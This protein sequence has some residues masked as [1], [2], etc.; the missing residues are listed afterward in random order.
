MKAPTI[1]LNGDSKQTLADETMRALEAISSAINAINGMTINGRN[2][3]GD[4]AGHVQAVNDFGRIYS[5]LRAIG[6][7]LQAY[8]I[9]IVDQ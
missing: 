3:P 7:E 9:D 5:G 2:Y 1:N 4:R 8:Y 6:E